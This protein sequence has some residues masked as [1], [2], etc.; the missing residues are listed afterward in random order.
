MT[1]TA[2][3]A[4]LL[5][6]C[7]VGPDFKHPEVAPSN[8]YT[9]EK[10][11]LQAAAGKEAKQ[12]LAIGSKISGQWWELFH[13][14]R[15]NAVLADAL[16]ANQTLLAARAS[17]EQAQSA[18]N[19]AAGAFWPHVQMTTSV[20]RQQGNGA[21]SGF[22]SVHND[23]SLYTI[24]PNVSYN[25][26]I[27][28]LT[29]RQVEQQQ[30]LAES[31]EYQ[32]DAAYLTLC[33]N[34]V[35]Q[36]ITI[37]SVRQQIEIYREIIG[38]DQR[39]LNNVSQQ[40]ALGEA[41]R[42]D[43]E[44]ART[45]LN[46]DRAALPPLQQQL[47]AAKHA[48]AT[49][50][51]KSPAEWVAPDFDLSEFNLPGELPVSVPSELLRQRPDILDAEA[52]LHAASAAI[53]VATASMYPR[54]DLSATFTQQAVDPANLFTGAGS[55][56][57]IAAQLTA[58]IFQGGT[59]E[60]QRKGAI[61]QF[62]AQAANYQQTVLT[63]FQ[64]VAD[65]LTQ[66]QNDAQLLD[67]QRAA[68]ESADAARVLVQETY[69]GGG[70]TVLQVLDAER[71]YAQARLGYTRTRGQRLVD[72]AQLFNAMGGGWWDWRAKDMEMSAKAKDSDMSAKS[73]AATAKP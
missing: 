7:T 54:V 66:I 41:T 65:T 33:G 20:S 67:E 45:Q 56:W 40:L 21:S 37:A 50:V 44:Q 35:N 38:D 59:L 15:L 71:S 4:A 68:T 30:A 28:G 47:S 32:L 61:A 8:G 48:L 19:A 9:S 39:N 31:R 70:V 52:Q 60:A 11:D 63:S 42:F 49:L 46:T 36:V 34:V 2:G 12:G 27:F 62:K 55:I 57:S 69:R 51:G 14:D 3:L 58:P 72:S 24:G 5:A 53:G 29:R 22:D 26:D 25:L 13:S 64:Q 17:L 6:G 18:I 10:L 23:F 16:V 43:L 73:A 1:A